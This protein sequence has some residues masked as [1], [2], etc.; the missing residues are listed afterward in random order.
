MR[1]QTDPNDESHFTIVC[2]VCQLDFATEQPNAM[3][4]PT[5][6]MPKGTLTLGRDTAPYHVCPPCRYEGATVKFLQWTLRPNKIGVDIIGALESTVRV[7]GNLRQYLGDLKVVI[8]DLYG[9]SEANKRIWEITTNIENL[10]AMAESNN[11]V[12]I[13]E[14]EDLGINYHL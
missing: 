11:R 10:I 6:N 13:A 8:S 3:G 12:A 14:I 1:S 7:C 9:T 5:D 2:D 4:T